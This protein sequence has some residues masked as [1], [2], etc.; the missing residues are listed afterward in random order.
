MMR[1]VI[2]NNVGFILNWVEIVL[3]KMDFRK[4]IALPGN[5]ILLKI[6]QSYVLLWIV[7]RRENDLSFQHWAFWN[8]NIKCF[9]S[10]SYAKLW[11]CVIRSQIVK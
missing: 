5:E 1:V 10:S 7:T 2:I 3:L 8:T 9:E 6:N 11:F 4:F